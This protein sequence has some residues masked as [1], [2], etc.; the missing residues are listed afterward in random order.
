MQIG[1]ELSLDEVELET[2]KVTLYNTLFFWTIKDYEN[3]FKEETIEQIQLENKIIYVQVKSSVITFFALK[4]PVKFLNAGL[5][6]LGFIL[7][8][9]V[10]DLVYSVFAKDYAA[11]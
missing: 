9:R 8:D 5:Y 7:Y 10:D 11:V 3:I 4:F 1:K 2:Y 6:G